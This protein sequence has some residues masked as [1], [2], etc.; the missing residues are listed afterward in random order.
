MSHLMPI[1]LSSADRDYDLYPTPSHYVVSFPFGIHNVKGIQ[2]ASLEMPGIKT[3]F[4]IEQGINDRVTFSEGLRIDLGETTHTIES[5]SMYNNQLMIK[6]GSNKYVVSIPSYLAQIL[7]FDGGDDHV[8][9]TD[10]ASSAG[11]YACY[12]D[13]Y[14]LQ[15]EP[16]PIALRAIGGSAGYVDHITS[17]GTLGQVGHNSDFVHGFVHLGA[18]SVTEICSYFTYAFANYTTYATSPSTP[19]ANSYTFEYHLGNVRIRSTST[20]PELHFPTNSNQSQS[21]WYGSQSNGFSTRMQLNSSTPTITSIGYMLGL[22]NPS[23]ITTK[24]YVYKTQKTSCVGFHA[25]TTPRWLFE[26]RLRPG[27]YT[28]S[29]LATALPIAL[30]PLHFVSSLN[31][32]TTGACYFGFVDSAHNEQLVVLNEGKYTVETFCQAIEHALNRLDE[33]GGYSS[34]NRFAYKYGPLNYT[35]SSAWPDLS[36]AEVV[37]YNVYYD[38][39]TSKFTI[40]SSWAST[41]KPFDPSTATVLNTNRPKPLFGL[42]FDPTTLSRIATHLSETTTVCALANT[43]RIANVLGLHLQD[44]QGRGTYT[45]EFE[46]HIPRIG[47][48]LSQGFP[49]SGSRYMF[50]VQNPSDLGINRGDATSAGTPRY[51]YPAGKYRSVGFV[52]TRQS[53]NLSTASTRAHES[54]TSLLTTHGATSPVVTLT[55]SGF[56]T[57]DYALDPPGTAGSRLANSMYLVGNNVVANDPPSASIVQVATTSHDTTSSMATGNVVDVGVGSMTSVTSTRTFDPIEAY[58]KVRMVGVTNVGS[59]NERCMACSTHSNGLVNDGKVYMTTTPFGVQVSDIVRMKCF[60]GV[61]SGS[62]TGTITIG[63]TSGTNQGLVY[64]ESFVVSSGTLTVGD[65][66]IVQAGDRNAIVRVSP[67]ASAVTV[68]ETGSGYFPNGTY[69]LSLPILPYEI[70]AVVVQH[71]NSGGHFQD[72]DNS[73]KEQ[74]FTCV[75]QLDLLNSC[76]P[77]KTVD[78]AAIR[79][80]IP[81]ALDQYVSTFPRSGNIQRIAE[82]VPA[83]IGI[84]IEHNNMTTRIKPMHANEVLGIGRTNLGLDYTLTFPNAMNVDPVH[85]VMVKFVGLNNR[86]NEQIHYTNNKMLRDV[87]GKVVLGAPTSIVRSLVSRIEFAPHTLDQVEVE[88]YLPDGET[89][90]NFHGR[91]HTLTLNLII[92]EPVKRKHTQIE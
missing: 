23:Y 70:E 32:S 2:L 30:N 18:L 41:H 61:V 17:T 79:V 27:I 64:G 28:Q 9:T 38:F 55:Q 1:S 63:D 45:S 92:Q 24:Q 72:S 62:T 86:R 39:N 25:H 34:A 11:W 71:L 78:G 16:K 69:S 22:S 14:T 89:K 73:Q 10:V 12:V 90:Y 21:A 74:F 80:R 49:P 31:T 46:S 50:R 82:F 42:L 53:L 44:Y 37:V 4:T 19:L 7:S 91:E 8:V 3:Q 43:D 47:F 60:S 57:T 66:H 52:P 85:Y 59:G 29:S 81:F 35:T 20:T 67:G 51:L 54:S 58:D 36:L 26:A 65:Y 40:E 76:V 56:R 68:A 88:F 48:P 13:W 87:A 33:N 75:P 6:E 77:A 15:P 5:T 83:R 84:H